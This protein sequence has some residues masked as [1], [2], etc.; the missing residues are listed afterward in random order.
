MDGD[1]IIDHAQHENIDVEAPELPIG[2]VDGQP[3][4]FPLGQQVENQ[5]G[6]RIRIQD[7]RGYEALDAPQ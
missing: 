2:A 4:V 7:K 6:K 1:P 3:E 5:Q